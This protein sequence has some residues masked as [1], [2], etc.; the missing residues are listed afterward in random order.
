MS[1][2]IAKW[3]SMAEAQ[4]ATVVVSGLTSFVL[5]FVWPWLGSKL[6]FV[7]F[8][9]GVYAVGRKLAAGGHCDFRPNLTG[10]VAIVT[11]ANTGIGKETAFELLLLGA[12]VIL[13]CR[14]KARAEGAQAEIFARVKSRQ[15]AQAAETAKGRLHVVELDLCNF[16][17]IRAFA[18]NVLREFPVIDILVNNAGIMVPPFQL[19]KPTKNAP[20]GI[21]SQFLSNHLGHFLLTNL[22]LENIKKS[23]AGRIVNLSSAAH[24]THNRL[25]LHTKA[26]TYNPVTAYGTSKL[27]NILFTRELQKRLKAEPGNKVTVYSCHPGAVITELVRYVFNNEVSIKI[28]EFVSPA[29]ACV[30][31]FPNEGC[32]TSLYCA[33]HPNA[34]PGEYHSDCKVAFCDP[35]GQDM[36]LASELWTLSEKL[37]AAADGHEKKQ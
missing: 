2:I 30:L 34:Q 35:A 9:F 4:A 18:A 12:D 1:D 22:L 23:D 16:D 10:K 19:I 3:K 32:Q 20:E 29:A 6:V 36:A 15:G 8:L 14:S 21:E 33:L 26:E 27:S 24:L 37:I 25:K 13:A 11:G 28:F 5:W 31:K 7:W 17:S